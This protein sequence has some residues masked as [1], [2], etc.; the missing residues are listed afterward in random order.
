LIVGLCA[1]KLLVVLGSDLIQQI[2]EARGGSAAVL[3]VPH[4]HDGEFSSL[5]TA[6]SPWPDRFSTRRDAMIKID[7]N[8]DK[9]AS[10]GSQEMA[11]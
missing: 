9:A 11:R 2:I 8:S 3:I 1:L 7:V 10:R 5:S 4:G 6:Q